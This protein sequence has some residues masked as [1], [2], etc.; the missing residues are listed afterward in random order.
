MFLVFLFFLLPSLAFSALP[1]VSCH[2]YP[3]WINFSQQVPA[4]TLV[5]TNWVDRS[6]CPTSDYI[7]VEKG[8][9]N[10]GCCI[11]SPPFSPPPSS[12]SF[13]SS[14][15]GGGWPPVGGGSDSLSFA[16]VVS[17]VNVLSYVIIAACFLFSFLL[18]YS[19]GIK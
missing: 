15:S 2:G 6:L 18:G 17:S 11:G 5:W 13:P 10:L 9:S 4:G 19:G 16:A 14:D 7:L 12:S 1:D 3:E 8:V